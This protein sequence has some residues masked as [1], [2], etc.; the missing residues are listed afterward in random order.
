[1]S[2]MFGFAAAAAVAAMFC[3]GESAE[4]RSCCRQAR[5]RCCKPVRTRCCSAPKTCCA[6]APTCC[7]PAATCTT[8]CTTGCAAMPANGGAAPAK[9]VSPAPE[10]PV[11]KK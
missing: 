8:G 3:V 5:V 2:R 10:P 4:A 7:A 11:E 9:E 6:P 1:M